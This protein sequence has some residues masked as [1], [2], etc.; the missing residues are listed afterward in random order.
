M[1]QR[2]DHTK[3]HMSQDMMNDLR[4]AV[5]C[6]PYISYIRDIVIFESLRQ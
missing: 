1:I 2:S 4:S 5:C 3:S 6:N